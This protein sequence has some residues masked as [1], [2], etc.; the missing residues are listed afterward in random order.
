[1][2]QRP[3]HE[4]PA[5]RRKD[6]RRAPLSG[7]PVD[8]PHRE[9]D[10]ADDEGPSAADLDRFGGV[11]QTCP[12]CGAEIYDEAAVCWKCGH[13]LGDPADRKSPVWLIVVVALVIVGLVLLF[14]LR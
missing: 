10:D 12:S 5:S 11:T 9:P 13:A 6:L 2:S 4:P 14:V 3:D 8:R 7:E 1:M